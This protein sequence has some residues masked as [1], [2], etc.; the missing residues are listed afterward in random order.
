[1][2]SDY[3]N[4]IRR[5]ERELAPTPPPGTPSGQSGLEE[6]STALARVSARIYGPSGPPPMTDA[7][8]RDFE[9]WRGEF[10]AELRALDHSTSLP[11]NP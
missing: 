1:M 5:L 11:E 8:R 6:I 7:E 2:S 3:R 9:E 10:R 4:R